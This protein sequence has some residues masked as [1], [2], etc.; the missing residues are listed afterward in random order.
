MFCLQFVLAVQFIFTGYVS[1]LLSA[2]LCLPVPVP[3]LGFL[4]AP[5]FCILPVPVFGFCQ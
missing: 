2:V 4:P 3:V 5:G 1:G